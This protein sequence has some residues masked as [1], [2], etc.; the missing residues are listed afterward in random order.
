MSEQDTL[1]Y[2]ARCLCGCGGIV[3]AVVDTPNHKKETAKDVADAIKDGY[4]V[5][6]TTVGEVRK[7]GVGCKHE[8]QRN[9]AKSVPV[10]QAELP[11]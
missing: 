10:S 1:C 7:Q 8:K 4:T 2:I 9:L 5:E 11:M 3:L 6:L